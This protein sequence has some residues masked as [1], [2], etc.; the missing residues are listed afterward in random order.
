[1]TNSIRE[2]GFERSLPHSELA[3]CA[4]LGNVLLAPPLISQVRAEL[5]PAQFYSSA[6]KRIYEAMIALDDRRES[7][8]AV[9]VIEELRTEGALETVGGP[10]Y[11]TNL[12]YGLPRE[13]IAGYAKVIRDKAALRQLIKLASKI[14]NEALEEE[15]EPEVVFDHAEAELFSLASL[16]RLSAKSSVRTYSQIAVSV[17][18]DFRQWA[19]GI[20]TAIPTQIPELDEKLS[21]GGLSSG[22]LIAIAARTS[23][24]KSALALQIALSAARA[25]TP[26]LILSL[27]MKGERLMI[28]NLASVTDVPHYQIRPQTFQN[29]SEL[30]RKIMAGVPKVA[31]L[32]IQVDDKT[33]NIH[34]LVAL[35]RDWRRRN[36]KPKK[37]LVI[38]DYMQLVHNQLQGRSREQEVAGI[39]KE[40][41]SLAVE[42]DVA[43]IGVSQF[44][45][46]QAKQNRKPE[47][48][49]LR[50]SGQIEN[51]CDLVLFPWSEEFIKD[52]P[53]RAL[54]LYCP[55]QRGG[56]VGWEI[57]I[58]FDADH[59]WF[60]TEQMYRDAGRTA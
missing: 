40:L 13:N 25:G 51:D 47:L 39:S 59:Q 18:D 17:M 15:D 14:T 2:Q 4:V 48:S 49:D 21:H 32:P 3:E 60:W 22:D 24:G 56:K 23:Y 9:L 29:N 33:R 30:A 10:S 52:V 38:T 1:M 45:R 54:K 35:T 26:S 34:Q 58:D 46:E 27:E 20:A 12:I 11:L 41:K 8:D 42:L 5:L 19:D 36:P 53:K 31:D 55:K 6:R 50:E 44:S 57:D 37:G 16:V 28:R 43:M 7:V